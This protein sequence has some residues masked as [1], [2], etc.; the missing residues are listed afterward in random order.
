MKEIHTEIEINAPAKVVWEILM[1]FEEFPNWNPFMKQISGNP[2]EGCRIEVFLQPPNS[3]GMTFKPKILEHKSEEKLRWI[4]NLWIPKIFDGEHSLI[5]KKI[6][7]NKVLFIQ[8]ERFTG[9]F[10]PIL[11][12]LLKN[13]KQGFEMMNK[14]LKKEA[15]KT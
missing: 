4:G 8:K 12:G 10:V 15:E 9:I 5:I 7:E 3:R 2:Q 1:N 11:G 13:S 6:N 14:A